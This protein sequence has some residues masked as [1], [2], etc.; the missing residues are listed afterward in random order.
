MIHRIATHLFY[1]CLVIIAASVAAALV[2]EA[3]KWLLLGLSL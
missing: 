1:T 2:W 3:V